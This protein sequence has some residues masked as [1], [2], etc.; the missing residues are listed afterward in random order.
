MINVRNANDVRPAAEPA[1]ATSSSPKEGAIALSEEQDYAV[2]RIICRDNVYIAGPSFSGKST[3]INTA[4]RYMRY[5]GIRT[6]QCSL[7]ALAADQIGGTTLHSFFKLPLSLMKDGNLVTPDIT[8]LMEV[9]VLFVNYCTQCTP[10]LIDII[11]N[12]I[13]MARDLGH[14]VQVVFSGDPFGLCSVMDYERRRQYEELVG[15]PVTQMN[16]ILSRHWKDFEFENVFLSKDLLH[17]DTA[18]GLAL[19][20]IR[21]GNA[22]GLDRM[23]PLLSKAPIP[24]AVWVYNSRTAARKKNEELVAAFPGEP[25]EFFATSCGDLTGFEQPSPSR[26]VLKENMPIFVTANIPSKRLTNGTSGRIANINGRRV[27][28]TVPG[29]KGRMLIEEYSWQAE[30]GGTY[31]QLPL[32]EGFATTSYRL[33]YMVLDAINVADDFSM[34]GVLYNV[35]SRGITPENIYLEKILHRQGLKVN[36]EIYRWYKANTDDSAK[37]SYAL[38]SSMDPIPYRS[39]NGKR[40]SLLSYRPSADLQYSFVCLRRLDTHQVCG[41][42]DLYPY[43]KPAKKVRSLDSDIGANAYYVI[44]FLNY[45]FIDGPNPVDSIEDITKCIYSSVRRVSLIVYSI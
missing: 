44:M 3:V 29:R 17:A 19:D 36:R 7:A 24:N 13:Q 33:R 6:A 32:A 22:G 43:L 31:T 11:W 5:D 30:N 14:Y 42:V 28:I 35:A 21:I 37:G 26:L 45:A 1:W 18:F 12:A 16:P 38:Y 40:F 8:K 9:D 20:E 41:V 27:Y 39:K 2:K 34:D 10:P 15:H 4:V 25:H 23:I